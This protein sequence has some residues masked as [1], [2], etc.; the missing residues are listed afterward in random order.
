MWIDIKVEKP[1]PFTE[2]LLEIDGHRNPMW[3][4]NYNVVAY[5]DLGGDFHEE[6]HENIIPLESIL[7][8]TPLPSPPKYEYDN[9]TKKWGWKQ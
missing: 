7:F 6:R 8:W 3:R 2:V 5:M 1:Q 9:K 4:N